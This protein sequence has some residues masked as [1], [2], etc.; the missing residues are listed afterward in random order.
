MIHRVILLGMIFFI[1]IGCQSNA[2][3]IAKIPEASGICFSKKSKTLFVV[4]D[5]GVLYE[6]SKDGKILQKK[7]IGHHDLEGVACDDKNNRLLLV[8]EGKDNLLIVSRQN[9]K[10][11]KKL[12]IKRDYKGETLLKKDKHHGLEGVTIYHD[13]VLLVN[14][15]NKKYPAIDPSI[16]VQ[17]DADTAR[18]KVPIEQIY[19][20]HKK[21]ISG[22]CY[23]DNYLYMVSD[24]KDNIIKYDIKTQKVLMKVKL[25]IFA[26]EGVAFDDEGYVYFADD[27]GRVLKYKKE[28][29]GL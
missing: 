12:N 14:Q 11:T 26:Q 18:A 13:K 27:N 10:L 22:L 8:D 24:N 2:N 29:F 16:I 20:P 6:I 28:K 3:E 7:R 5:K 21:D 4:S 23:H 19:N 1:M 9:L 17:I 15:S 25:P